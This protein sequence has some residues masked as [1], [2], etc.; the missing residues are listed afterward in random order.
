MKKSKS[1]SRHKKLARVLMF[2]LVI[3]SMM[4]GALVAFSACDGR[5]QLATPTD[6]EFD[7]ISNE[8]SWSQVSYSSGG[9]AIRITGVDNEFSHTIEMNY[10]DTPTWFCVNRYG[11][12][13]YGEPIIMCDIY[14]VGVQRP[15][16]HCRR[17]YIPGDPC[18]CIVSCDH[19]PGVDLC[20]VCYA[21]T[22]AICWEIINNPVET[23]PAFELRPRRTTPNWWKIP[24]GLTDPAGNLLLTGRYSI[25]VMARTGDLQF[26][27]D[28]EWSE[29]EFINYERA[30]GVT[31]RLINNST[32]YEVSGL[33][34]ALGHVEIFAYHNGL[35]ITAIADGAFF[36]GAAAGLSSIVLGPNINRIG[37]DAFRNASRLTS[38]VFPEACQATGRTGVTTI[39]A[40]AFR[41]AISLTEMV[42]PDTVTY[43][44]EFAFAFASQLTSVTL[45]S[46]LR[47]V[48]T[49]SFS[50]ANNLVNVVLGPNV[51]VIGSHAFQATANLRALT[52]PSS[53]RHIESQ[54]FRLSGI[55]RLVIPHGVTSIDMHAFF[56]ATSL[57]EVQIPTTVTRIGQNAFNNTGIWNN[58]PTNYVYV[59][60]RTNGYWLVGHRDP[61]ITDLIVQRYTVGIANVAFNGFSDLVNVSLPDTLIYMGENAFGRV[62]NENPYDNTRIWRDQMLGRWLTISVDGW[63][64]AAYSGLG[65]AL[66]PSGTVGI[67][68]GVFNG[69]Q[70]IEHIS[71]PAGVRSIGSRAFLG[72]TSVW[73]ISLPNGLRHIGDEAFRNASAAPRGEPYNTPANGA[74]FIHIPQT[75]TSIGAYAF[76][77]QRVL[78]DVTIPANITEI[79]DGLF[80]ANHAMNRVTLHNNIT[81]I[82]AGAF[83]N[84]PELRDFNMPA[85]VTYIGVRAFEASGIS[86]FVL[87]S[88]ATYIND[89]AFA[90]TRNLTD[91]VIPEGV[92]HIGNDA[93]F[94]SGASSISLPSTLRT[95]GTRAFSHMASLAEID[96]PEGV[97][98][99]SD[100]LF[101]DSWSLTRIGLPSTLRT[102]GDRS[103]AYLQNIEVLDLPEGITRVGRYA[104]F[105][106]H[107][108]QQV[109]LP[110]TLRGIGEYAFA[111]NSSLRSIV[112]PNNIRGI[113]DHAFFGCTNL[114][115]YAEALWRRPGWSVHF[116]SSQRPIVWD[117]IISECLTYVEGVRITNRAIYDENGE[118]IGRTRR[119][120]NLDAPHNDR[121]RPASRVVAAPLHPA[122]A[123]FLGWSL[124]PRPASGPDTRDVDY[125]H[126]EIL[127]VADGVTLFA[128]WDFES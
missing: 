126:S 55:E 71:I 7:N 84:T 107:G 15:P 80:F 8:I 106:I 20:D 48:P 12:D 32:E 54:A 99:L 100:E 111:N 103:M 127:Y 42:I 17:C 46:G 72:N 69:N 112:L 116:N 75:V 4:I 109:I 90:H 26:Y 23:E 13:E 16:E 59:G 24:F 122:G 110:S 76:A 82:G 63:L 40:S 92:V 65:N 29:P 38:I 2:S 89:S 3:L 19:I 93:F 119:I 47:R 85:A 115:I 10:F 101:R 14:Y 118:E 39:G 25:E 95:I 43:I 57:D 104:F 60:N 83:A 61:D 78:N 1:F 27:R 114:T 11:T 58:S 31:Y 34:E 91:V 81:R 73:Q 74:R 41:A 35:P 125:F 51:T 97:I 37:E 79:S 98:H 70:M 50:G 22:C 45:P 96:I 53:L 121:D 18:E 9:Y 86:S 44:G 52:L 77:L 5:Q 64:V 36:G 88:T 120:S 62:G 94:V 113:G 105:R 6:I 67:G 128:L 108:L 68:P 49:A 30:S 56:D 123:T 21:F 102:I 28:S 124:Q 87:P 33:G 117:S 66:I